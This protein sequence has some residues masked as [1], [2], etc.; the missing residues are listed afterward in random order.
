MNR[1]DSLRNFLILILYSSTGYFYLLDVGWIQLGE[2][3]GNRRNNSTVLQ[4]EE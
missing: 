1:H 4:H 2:V 3:D